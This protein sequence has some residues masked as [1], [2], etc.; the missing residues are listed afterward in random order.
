LDIDRTGDQVTILWDDGLLLS[1]TL[2]VPIERIEIVFSHNAYD[3]PPLTSVFGTESVD[4]L[5]VEG[6]PAGIGA[7][8][9]GRTKTRYR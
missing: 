3:D 1:D 8:S 9:W 5:N 6:T 7:R 2:S 4:L